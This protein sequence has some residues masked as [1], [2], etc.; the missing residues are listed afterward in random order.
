MSDAE[1]EADYRAYAKGSAIELA[2]T[3]YCAVSPDLSG[4]IADFDL[5]YALDVRGYLEALQSAV[6][7]ARKQLDS[8]IAAKLEGVQYYRHRDQ[9]VKVGGSG[10]WK[11]K[12]EV[13]NDGSLAAFIGPDWPLTVNL[14]AQGAV[15]K[16]RIE[17]LAANK[18]GGE[19]EYAEYLKGRAAQAMVNRFFDYKTNDDAISVMPADRAPKKAQALPDGGK[20]ERKPRLEGR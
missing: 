13:V 14:K 3:A 15:T 8:F 16:T 4:D 1:A 20:I 12:D 11:V 9:I 18:M 17:E 5:T 10:T 19:D 2:T 6:R 7:E